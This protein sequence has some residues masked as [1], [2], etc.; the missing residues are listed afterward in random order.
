M[1]KKQGKPDKVKQ[2]KSQNLY[3]LFF[4][5]SLIFKNEIKGNHKTGHDPNKIIG[6]K[7]GDETT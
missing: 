1:L 7:F 2:S 3:F 6:F 4:Y 5:F